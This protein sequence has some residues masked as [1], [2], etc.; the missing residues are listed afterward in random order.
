[1]SGPILLVGCGGHGKVVLDTAQC[2]GWEVSGI[3]D[4]RLA[5]G[6]AVFGIPVLGGD[7]ALTGACGFWLNG[8]G[9]NPSTAAR[10]ALFARFAGGMMKAATLVHP[11]A[12]VSPHAELGA[13]TQAMAG[14]IVQ[15]GSVLGSNCVINTGARIDHDCTLGD[16]VFISPA[17]IL[18][19]D[20]TVGDGAFIGAG[21]TILPGCR[22]GARAVVGAGA[23]VVR[24]IEPAVTVIGIPARQRASGK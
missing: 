21:S 23:L 10:Q 15:P 11:A 3:V 12:T 16:H 2:A 17:A 22:I 1:M 18:C 24:D 5:K 7:E 14:A 4:P 6:G 13:G 19:G 20:V 8:V 9:A